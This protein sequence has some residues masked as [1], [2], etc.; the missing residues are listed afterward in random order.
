MISKIW[1]FFITLFWAINGFSQGKEL[2]LTYCQSCHL[3][4]E[5]SL[6]DKKT[7]ANSVLPNMGLRLG[8]KEAG[9]NPYE[10]LDP[11]EEA[12]LRASGT[13]PETPQLSLDVWNQI[14]DFYVKAAPDSPLLQPKHALSQPKL[15]QFE[16]QEI[17]V[18]DKP[19]PQT[20]LVKFNPNNG[21][22]YVGDAQNELYEVDSLLQLRTTWNVDSPPSAILFP[23]NV[24]PRLL[25]IGSFRPSEQALG[26]LIVLDTAVANATLYFDTIQRGVDFA[27]A[28]LNQDGKE[29][30]VIC[31]FGN[32][33]GKLAW[34]ESMLPE[35]EY[36][37]LALPGARKVEI[38]DMNNDKKPDIVVLMAQAR[39]SIHIFYNLGKGQFSEKVVLQFPPVYGVSYFELVDFNKDGAMDILLT[40]GDNWDYSAISKNYHGIR[41]FLNDGKDTFKE[42]WFYPLFGTSKAVARD[43]D[44]DGDLDIAAISFYDDLNQ[45]EQGFLYFSNKGNLQFD[46]SSTPAAATGKWLTLEAADI[47]RDGDTDLLLGSY[48]HNIGELT[49]LMFK[50][51][52]SVP[53]LLV[54]K[55]KQK[56]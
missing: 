24:P 13:Y 11:K 56:K 54:L 52:F 46:V 6:L 29:D 10:D 3:Y 4:P 50:G 30:V 39:E 12:L 15:S 26:K 1:G 16:A 43:F 40:N 38:R 14:V 55:N 22:L 8:I 7:W 31:H 45:P 19:I 18:H 5:P 2:A 35:K 21:I 28:D 53:Q 32:N 41:I 34:Y 42:A 25:T 27:T 9:K 36:V 23:R 51:I 20:S 37:L 33:T 49:K 17:K 48:F 44:N 47:D